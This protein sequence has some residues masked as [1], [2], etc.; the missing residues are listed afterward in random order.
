MYTFQD[1]QAVDEK[2]KMEFLRSAINQ[3]CGTKD[4]VDAEI[5]DSY[6]KR[7]NV[8]IMDFHSNR[9]GNT[10]QLQRQLQAQ[11][12]LVSVL[13]HTAQSVPAEQRRDMERGK[14]EGQSWQKL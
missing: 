5:A 3:Y 4:Y 9:Q 13:C 6:F 7:Q 12:K 14:H 10:R 11:V 2:D 1:L 8:T